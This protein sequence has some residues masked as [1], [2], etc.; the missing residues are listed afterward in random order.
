MI[1]MSLL[2]I[3]DFIISIAALALNENQQY[4]L[5]KNA[6]KGLTAEDRKNLQARLHCCNFDNTT[7]LA[8]HCPDVSIANI[9]LIRLIG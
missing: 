7:A 3:L 2:F 6:F 9:V 4:L 5:L 8:D 1:L